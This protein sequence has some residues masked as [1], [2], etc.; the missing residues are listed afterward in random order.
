MRKGLNLLLYFPFT[1]RGQYAERVV[2][3]A[4]LPIYT[5]RGEYGK[6]CICCFT[7]RLPLEGEYGKGCICCFTSR[8]RLEGEYRKGCICCFTSRLPLEGE[9]RKGSICCFT[10]HLHLRRVNVERVL[11]A[12]FVFCISFHIDVYCKLGRYSH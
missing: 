9:Y 4:L 6:G 1:L 5:Q 8:L 10:S 7:S 2:S 3:A 12:A 11:F